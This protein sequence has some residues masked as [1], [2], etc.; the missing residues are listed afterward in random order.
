M[1][2][3]YNTL[4]FL[5]ALGLTAYLFPSHTIC[6]FL[7]ITLSVFGSYYMLLVA[8]VSWKLQYLISPKSLHLS[9]HALSI[10]NY[11][12]STLIV[13]LVAYRIFGYVFCR[14]VPRRKIFC[15]TELLSFLS[16]ASCI[17]TPTVLNVE[18]IVKWVLIFMYLACEPFSVSYQMVKVS[19]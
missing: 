17:I 12:L 6:L 18:S 9:Y 2:W 5:V 15:L 10:I 11:S 4:S 1:F 3:L 7:L 14:F 13:I 16:I 8:T 19:S